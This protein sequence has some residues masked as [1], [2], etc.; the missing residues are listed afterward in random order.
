MKKQ[1]VLGAAIGVALLA[2]FGLLKFF[3]IQMLMAGQAGH[4]PPPQAVTTT[5]VE[6]QEWEEI[7]SAVGELDPIRGAELAFQ[8]SGVV[9]TVNFEPGDLVT[10]GQMLA[11]LDITVEQADLDGSEAQLKL[12][13]QEYLRYEKL[14]KQ[15]ATSRSEYEKRQSEFRAEE[16]R[17]HSLRSTI[18]RRTIIAPFDG[19]LGTQKVALGEYVNAGQSVVTLVDLSELYINFSIPERN[20]LQV[21]KGDSIRFTTD[22]V[23]GREFEAKVSSLEAIVASNT[24]NLSLQAKT[25]NKEGLFKPGMFV[26]VSIILPEKNT[27]PTIPVSSVQYAPYGNTVYVVQDLKNP[28]G[29]GTYKGVLSRNVRLGEVRGDRVSVLKGLTAGEEIV[30]SGTF[31]LFPNA[32]VIINNEVTPGESLNP[33][34]PNT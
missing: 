20:A 6:E 12:A 16:A 3:Q 5:V 18:N 29:E 17:V 24:R 7:I 23:P 28:Q 8:A 9:Q 2:V 31:K 14:M 27:F 10:A 33:T 13:E 25:Q 11:Q 21:S 34:P 30:S 22:A 26:D 19:T 1:I 15:K 32:P 4:G